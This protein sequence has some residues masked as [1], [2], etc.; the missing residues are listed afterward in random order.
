MS[1]T[2]IVSSFGDEIERLET[3]LLDMGERV[4]V[5][6]QNATAALVNEDRTLAKQAIKQDKKIN[7]LEAELNDLAIQI[8]ALR[9][10]FAVD[11]RKVVMTLKI[12]GHLERI[13]DLTRN[14]AQRTN[15]ITKAEA[16]WGSI[17]TL[18]RMSELVQEMITSVMTAY[19]DHDAAIAN[20]V[21]DRDEM[22]D[23]A[24]NRLFRELL[25][26]MMEDMRNISGCMHIMFIAKNIERMGD[27]VADISKEV[28][29]LSTGEWPEGKRSKSDRTSKMMFEPDAASEVSPETS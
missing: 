5:Q 4:T 19:K 22:V 8:L 20:N 3:T 21:R 12:A 28:I 17:D 15:T 13:G 10:P 24:H 11:L 27:H 1:D 7:R 23:N 18:V 25:T 29:F 14:M 16:E 2:H 26:Y 6:L 9:H